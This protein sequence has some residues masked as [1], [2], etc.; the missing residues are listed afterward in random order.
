[1]K[2]IGKI[3]L[4]III[5]LSFS[6]CGKTT[7]ISEKELEKKLFKMNFTTKDV[8]SEMEDSSIKKVILATNNKLQVEYYV[9]K[10]ED[11]AKTAYNTNVKNLK[12]DK[13][14]KLKENNKN[15]YSKCRQT[16]KNMYI[17]IVRTGNTM[18]YS[19]SNVNYKSDVNKTMRKLGY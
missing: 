15:N 10:N 12:L 13:D 11:N 16:S 19:S 8:T 2:K 17:V 14:A 5:L 6:A 9:F 1:M 7:K 3:L 4:V 18:I